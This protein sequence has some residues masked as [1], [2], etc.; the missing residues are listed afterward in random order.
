MRSTTMFVSML[1]LAAVTLTVASERALSQSTTPTNSAPNPYRSIENWGKLP[2]GRQWGSTSAVAIDPD[3]TS[4]WVA[5]RCG[6]YRPPSRIDPSSPFAC[7]DS[8]LDPILKFDSNGNLLK[9]FGASI[10]LFPHGLHVDQ[11]GNVWVADG[12]GRG[13][14]GHQVFKFSPDGKLL[15]TLGKPNKPGSGPDEFNAP[16]AVVTSPNG[17]IFVADGHGGT[18]NARIVKFDKDG[19]FIKTWGKKGTGS[20]ELDIP[21]A[22]AIDQRGRLFV[23]DRQNNRIQI[24]DQDGN[25]VDQWHQ[26]SRPS[27]IHI[28]K[29]DIIYV[30]DSESESV[31]KNHDGWKRGIRVGRVSDG[32]VTAFIPDPV[33][34]TTGTS[35][36]E[37]VAADAI[38]NIYGA[39]VGPRRMMKY[40]RN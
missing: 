7:G 32:A 38:G 21:H 37:G 36:A 24:F 31:S 20:G 40:V 11:V 2:D 5:E 3:G 6:E 4:V 23:G 33:E 39:E 35:A 28:D 12:L 18:T 26:F 13:N 30:A 15:L 14:K 25:Y 22:V 17:D 10:L 19:K 8:T 16:S 27:G 29:N 9:S 1:G 34:K